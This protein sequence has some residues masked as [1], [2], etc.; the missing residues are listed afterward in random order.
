MLETPL[1][2]DS[3][4]GWDN[5]AMSYSDRF[6]GADIRS[7]GSLDAHIYFPPTVDADLRIESLPTGYDDITLSYDITSADMGGVHTG[8]I[9][10][11]AGSQDVS[12][13]LTKLIPSPNRYMRVSIDLPSGVTSVRFVSDGAV[14]T[15]GMRIDNIRL[16]GVGTPTKN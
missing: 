11:Y 7:H 8:A 15:Y 5:A 13:Q 12:L 10:V 9:R 14:N 6:G 16:E 4:T 2:I 1:K 3:Y